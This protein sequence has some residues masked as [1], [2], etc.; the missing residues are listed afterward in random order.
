M[1]VHTYQMKMKPFTQRRLTET[2]PRSVRS[3]RLEHTRH[4][5]GIDGGKITGALRLFAL[6]TFAWIIR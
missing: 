3:A 6:L 5:R 2:S 4:W 1:A